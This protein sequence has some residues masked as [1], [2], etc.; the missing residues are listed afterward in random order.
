VPNL[1]LSLEPH[2]GA[3][4]ILDGYRLVDAMDEIEVDIVGAKPLEALV[5]RFDDV[6]RIALGSGL[7]VEQANVAE[8]RCK[9]YFSRR[10]LSARPTN[11]SFAPFAP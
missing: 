10:P 1:A 7:A 4:R 9:E 11:S 5:A 2:H 3:D 8:L 6:V